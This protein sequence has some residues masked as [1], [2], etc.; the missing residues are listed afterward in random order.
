MAARSFARLAYRA[1]DA[2]LRALWDTSGR[3]ASAA[4]S[5]VVCRT[6]RRWEGP[7]PL[8]L[9]IAKLMAELV[10][11]ADFSRIKACQGSTCA[12]FFLDGTRGQ[13]KRWCSM[14]VCGNRAKQA[15]PS[16]AR[17]PATCPIAA[18]AEFFLVSEKGG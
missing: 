1:H 5:P 10:S 18:P 17:P 9:P 11:N 6:A 2:V 15:C 12:L 14:A 8:L 7:D 4:H 16:Q 3:G 13:A